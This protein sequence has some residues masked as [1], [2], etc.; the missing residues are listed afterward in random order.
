MKINLLNSKNFKYKLTINTL[1][2]KKVIINFKYK[3]RCYNYKLQTCNKRKIKM[4]NNLNQKKII[5]NLKNKQRLYNYK[6]Q[7]CNKR[8]NSNLLCQIILKNKQKR[9]KNK[10]FLILNN[11]KIKFKLKCNNN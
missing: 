8:M 11:L 3:K 7:I 6:L 10:Y 2:Q 1:N 5:N 4:I 9:I